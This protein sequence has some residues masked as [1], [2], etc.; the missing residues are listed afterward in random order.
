IMSTFPGDR[1]MLSRRSFLKQSATTAAVLT[2]GPLLLGLDKKTDTMNPVIGVEG[3]RYEC[4][5]G[6]GKLPDTLEWQTTHNVTLD[7]AGHVY[8]THQGHKGKKGMDCVLVFDAQGTFV[9]SFGA[10]WHGGGHGIEVRSEGTEEFLYFTNTWT[11][12]HKVVKTNLKGDI[13]WTMGRPECKEYE[14]PKIRYNP[15]NV[16]FLPDGGFTVGDG[17]GSNFVMIYDKDAKLK[18]V[19]G[20]SGKG[21][22]K[23][24]TPHGQWTDLRNTNHPMFVVC[25]RANARLQWFD[26]EG[27]FLK[28]SK[29]NEIVHYPAHAKTR[30]DVLMVPDLHTRVSLFDKDNNPIVHL[31]EE[32]EWRK[33]VTGSLSKGPAVRTQPKEWPAGKFIHPHDAAFDA[34]GNIFVVEWVE[35]G[36]ITFLKKVG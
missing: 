33:K 14:D 6:W 3:H 31:G 18:S 34:A 7:K 9:R 13:V 15:T 26:L 29:S 20:G 17:Y 19:F 2:T 1:S 16:S 21:D 35:G 23:F 4:Q 5:H 8:I 30:G 11:E 25:D 28:A 32:P 36:R 12:K 24:V 22:G 27:K 10:G